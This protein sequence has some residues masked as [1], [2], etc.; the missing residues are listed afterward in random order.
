[1]IPP[2]DR[3][4]HQPAAMMA[5]GESCCGLGDK[6]A[7]A[8]EGA[9]SRATLVICPL[10]AVIQ[11]RQEIAR[12]TA[13]GTLKVLLMQMLLLQFISTTWRASV[14]SMSCPSFCTSAVECKAGLLI[15]SP[16]I[17]SSCL[18]L[19]LSHSP[20]LSKHF[21]K[22]LHLLG[23]CRGTVLCKLSCKVPSNSMGL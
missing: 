21:I 5:V 16:L 20:T 18:Y 6:A 15:F 11:W 19:A 1:M 22:P 10:V 3:P 17:A 14:A 13:P 9:F 7:S 8:P 4:P 23:A 2:A 12:Y